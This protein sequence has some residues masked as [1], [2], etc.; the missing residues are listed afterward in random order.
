MTGQGGALNLLTS[1]NTV[2]YLF[3]YSPYQPCEAHSWSGQCGA[4][5][6]LW[7]H[8]FV[9]I[10]ISSL[11]EW[12]TTS[13][14]FHYQPTIQNC[15]IICRILLSGMWCLIVFKKF[16]DVLVIFTSQYSG[17][18]EMLASFY[19]NIWHHVPEHSVE[20]N[21]VNI[22]NVTMILICFKLLQLQ[23]QTNTH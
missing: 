1:F 13:T 16:T 17:S 10:N 23:I 14:H 3:C 4:W 15:V 12:A 21:A 18:T 11:A 9:S 8:K 6:W 20:H 19:Q 2:I 7:W 22:W 5:G